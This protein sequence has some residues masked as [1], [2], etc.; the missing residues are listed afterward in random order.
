MEGD[1][2]PYDARRRADG[3]VYRPIGASARV[4]GWVTAWRR[5]GSRVAPGRSWLHRGVRAALGDAYQ[6]QPARGVAGASPR[7]TGAV[8]AR[9][10]KKVPL[11]PPCFA[12]PCGSCTPGT[13]VR[14][15]KRRPA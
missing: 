12:F 7:L 6:P 9:K 4:R 10:V 2:R 11:R 3:E 5:A 15:A 8:G 14:P 13:A 1:A